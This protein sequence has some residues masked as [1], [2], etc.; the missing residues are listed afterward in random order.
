MES[1][2]SRTKEQPS[3][4]QSP[5]PIDEESLLDLVVRT[6]VLVRQ[7]WLDRFALA[8]AEAHLAA[9]SALLILLLTCALGVVWVLGWAVVLGSIAYFAL[10]QGVHWLTVA[11]LLLFSQVVLGCFL[12]W[13]IGRLS[14]W[15]TFPAMRQSFAVLDKDQTSRAEGDA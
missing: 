8:R 3:A 2:D 15:L 11:A 6:L 10:V 4:E 12:W 7:T 1:A 9:K 13:Q 14:R 5:P